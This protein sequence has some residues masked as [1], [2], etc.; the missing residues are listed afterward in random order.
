MTANVYQ[1]TDKLPWNKLQSG[2][3]RT[4][5]WKSPSGMPPKAA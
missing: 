4:G 3:V 5:N 1:A 2:L